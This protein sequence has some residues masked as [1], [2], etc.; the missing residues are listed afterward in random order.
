MGVA[1]PSAIGNTGAMSRRVG[2]LLATTAV[3]ALLWCGGP[4]AASSPAAGPGHRVRR[5]EVERALGRVSL[6]PIS[7]SAFPDRAF[8]VARGGPTSNDAFRAFD[9]GAF[10]AY[11]T[12]T[13]LHT[14]PELTG[15]KVAATVDM[16]TAD[17]VYA[18]QAVSAFS[19]ELG[20]SIVSSLPPGSGLAQARAV[21][22]D[23]PDALGDVDTGEPA[24]ATA[25]P[26]G[27]PVVR[28][29]TADL[30]PLLKA[31]ALRSE[32]SAR[33]VSTGCVIGN[34]LARGA[35]NADDT[36][37]AD[38]NPSAKSPNPLLS[39]SADDPPRAVSQSVAHTRL[40]PISGQ[41]GRFGAVTEV[42]QTIAPITFGLPGSDEKFTIEVAGEWVMRATADGTAGSVTFRSES[43]NDD[44]RPVLRLIHGKQVVDGVGLRDAGGREGIFVDGEPVGDIRIGGDPR[45]VAG[46]S[47]SA[48]TQTGTR[49]S[50]GDA[51]LVVLPF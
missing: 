6:R 49:V 25:P 15:T 28:E 24:K 8:P 51:T 30:T 22:V 43:R 32:A 2:P 27:Q 37:I 33:A 1:A 44:D 26:T 40:V 45:A 13:V 7:G 35:A 39:L 11:A 41:P 9:A 10:A 29:S 23:P 34:D 20:R 47:G 31:N 19:D 5:V 17:A 18:A 21:K 16:A 42:R 14:D 46:P 3:V 4:A 38:T 50:A 12:G 48:P 36:D